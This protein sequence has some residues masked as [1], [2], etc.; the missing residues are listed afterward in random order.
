MIF[1]FMMQKPDSYQ[2]VISKLNFEGKRKYNLG[3]S[4]NEINLYNY[5]YILYQFTDDLDTKNLKLI[6]KTEGYKKGIGIYKILKD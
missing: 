5:D 2:K 3:K 6:Y 1:P 4:I